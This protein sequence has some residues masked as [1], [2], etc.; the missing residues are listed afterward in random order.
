MS[1]AVFAGAPGDSVGEDRLLGG[2]V[3]ILQP[4]AGY[5]AAIDPV[6]LAAAVAARPGQSV[7]DVGCGTGAAALCLAARLPDCRIAGIESQADIAALARRSAGLN[8]WTDRIRVVT[9][10]IADPPADLTPGGFDWVMANP[11]YL[12]PGRADPPATPGRARAHRETAAV[13]L[14]EWVAFGLAMA[15]RKGRIVFIHRADRIAELVAAVQ[16]VAGDI[17]LFPFWPAA[18]RAAKRAILVA[19]KGTRGPTRLLPGLV[20]HGADGAYT[21]E[22]EA[23]LS[24]AAGLDLEGAGGPV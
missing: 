9:G 24:A 16:G 2:R 14:A 17:T 21:P 15:R 6:L 22:A 23:V 11:P 4:R 13:G 19:R 3:R 12:Q 18:G 20:L 8:G 7:L 10:D 5:R 1:G